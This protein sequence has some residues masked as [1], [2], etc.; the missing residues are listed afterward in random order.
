MTTRANEAAE[1]GLRLSKLAGI[2]DSRA[3]YLF[4]GTY[5]AFFLNLMA[6][7]SLH[8]V[9]HERTAK[10]SEES[11]ALNR[12][13]NNEQ[14]IA[15][16]LLIL[17]VAASDRGDYEQAE[18]FYA[19]GL[20]LS[21]ELD[22][23]YLRF[24]FLS[25][26]GWTALHGGDYQ[27]ATVLVEEAVELARERRR[28]FTGLLPRAL[29]TLG[30]AAL[31]GGDLGRA[32]TVLT[33]CLT[34]CK[35]LGDKGTLLMSLE[36]LACV[37]GAEGEGLRAARLFAAETLT[38]MEGIGYRL[39]PQERA[40]LEPYRVNVRSRLGER[41]W[42]E[43]VAEGGAIGLD[44]ASASSVDEL[45]TTTP[46]SAP[47]QHPG[48]L[49][50]REVEVLGLVASG[51][52]NAQVAKELFLSPRTI[53]RHLNSIYHKIGVSSRAAATRFAVEHGLV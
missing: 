52:T 21:R 44:E 9:E 20:S 3:P 26:W 53:Q 31:L 32:K 6:T 17:A 42:E 47:E 45:S 51:L 15:G 41:T 30:W 22:S 25:N 36:G 43:A 4:G 37:A 1:E 24:L 2:E 14:G 49:T 39:V 38:L 16:S 28:R 27:R 23:A 7:V 19:E 48:G 13:A 46:S 18:D 8:K 33:E 10:L 40:V 29:D 11:L 12:Q 35:E 34:L 5:R 50:S